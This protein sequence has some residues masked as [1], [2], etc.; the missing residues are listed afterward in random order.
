MCAD[1]G[2]TGTMTTAV[3]TV[4]TSIPQYVLFGSIVP[5]EVDAVG[6]TVGAAK[7]LGL[8]LRLGNSVLDIVLQHAGVLRGFGDLK[9]SVT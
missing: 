1:N 2:I 5:T 6:A 4:S 7:D 8:T 3:L 9:S